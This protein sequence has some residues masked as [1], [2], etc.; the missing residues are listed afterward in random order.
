VS[1]EHFAYLV[2]ALAAGQELM[3]SELRGIHLAQAAPV[4]ALHEP[5]YLKASIT[6]QKALRWDKW[7]CGASSLRARRGKA[8]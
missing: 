3:A 2:S 5:S 6:E 4:R 7:C 1:F 8:V